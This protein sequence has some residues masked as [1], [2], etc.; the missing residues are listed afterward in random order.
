MTT[1]TERGTSDTR[2]EP[3]R[4]SVVTDTRFRFALGPG[5]N[6][7]TQF[8]N[9]ADHLAI[10]NPTA[11][12][13]YQLVGQCSSTAWR[14]PSLASLGLALCKTDGVIFGQR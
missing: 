2:S 10:I 7:A 11:T 14:K 3:F 9:Y 1:V 8:R 12:A 4:L 13:D 6:D 5:L